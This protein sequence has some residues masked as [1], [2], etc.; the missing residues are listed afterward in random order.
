M[1]SAAATFYGAYDQ[2]A[3]TRA[4]RVRIPAWV[5]GI[6]VGVLVLLGFVAA[7]VGAFEAIPAKV[8][9]TAVNWFAGSQLLATSPGF[10]LHSTQT[11]SLSL[12]CNLICYRFSAAAVNAPFQVV[13][14]SVV[15]QPIQF[16]NV[17]VQAPSSAYSGPLNITLSVG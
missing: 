4:P 11:T 8:T 14:F 5:F 12:T 15:D 6:G 10:T 7:D 3:T 13:A 9:V 17:T 16:A 1:H 2:V